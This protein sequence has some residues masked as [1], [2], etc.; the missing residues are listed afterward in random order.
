MEQRN[1]GPTSFYCP[2][3]FWHDSGAPLDQRVK[4][5]GLLNRLTISSARDYLKHHPDLMNKIN[6]INQSLLQ[7]DHDVQQQKKEETKKRKTKHH[8][9]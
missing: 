6:D 3:L 8:K 2:A 7:Y 9:N 1:D 4:L 5:S